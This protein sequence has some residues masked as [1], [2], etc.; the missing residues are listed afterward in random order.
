MISAL[1]QDP[2]EWD[3][4][5]MG[6]NYSTSGIQMTQTRLP[7]ARCP[8]ASTTVTLLSRAPRRLFQA[9]QQSATL[10]STSSG[11]HRPERWGPQAGG[12]ELHPICTTQAPSPALSCF[13]GVVCS[14]QH[15]QIKSKC[16]RW[17]SEPPLL[18]YRGDCPLPPS[19]AQ[20]LPHP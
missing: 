7:L 13:A 4:G 6:A 12:A 20:N 10:N 18:P 5:R 2:A 1:S 3:N 9:H 8:F 14:Q 17:D 15:F 19:P 16:R 11:N